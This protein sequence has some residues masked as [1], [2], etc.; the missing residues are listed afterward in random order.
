MSKT[1][2]DQFSELLGDMITICYK[3]VNGQADTVYVYSF[4]AEHMS[5]SDCFFQIGDHIVYK[6]RVNDYWHQGQQ[7]V[8]TERAQ[9]QL[10]MTLLKDRTQ[11]DKLFQEHKREIPVEL[12]LVYDVKTGKFNTNVSYDPLPK[13]RTP[14][15]SR[16]M[17]MQEVAAKRGLNF[18]ASREA[19]L[20]DD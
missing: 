20:L 12:R 1:F 10:L 2:E 11:I 6:S 7:N 9:D 17:W 4:S 8:N 18:D 14:Q 5:F 19:Y 3:Y 15:L 16:Y 13:K